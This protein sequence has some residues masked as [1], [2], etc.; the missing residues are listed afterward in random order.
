L[1]LHW[2]PAATFIIGGALAGSRL[3]ADTVLNFDPCP[4]GTPTSPC[5]TTAGWAT[6]KN[7]TNTA[8]AFGDNVTQN[9][10]PNG[11]GY[12]GGSAD[13]PNVTV[14]FDSLSLSGWYYWGGA[15]SGLS[16]AA[17]TGSGYVSLIAAPGYQVTL[18]SFD[19][20]VFGAE[21]YDLEVFSGAPGSTDLLANY[22]GS[23]SGTA[24]QVYQPNVTADE[25]TIY[26]TNWNDGL[27]NIDFSQSS[28]TAST[29]PEPSMYGLLG[30]GLLGLIAIGRKKAVN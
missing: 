7:E 8:P 21:G 30:F 2:L 22:D 28:T 24:A 25:L 29:V 1:K 23:T 12:Y 15:E 14:Q 18:N 3:M 5:I 17:D 6:V 20:N 13:T 19:Y 4:S 27:Q 9:L 26:F 10:D 11:F 16:F